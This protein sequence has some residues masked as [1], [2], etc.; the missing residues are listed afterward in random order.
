[1]DFGDSLMSEVQISQ[2]SNASAFS[3]KMYSKTLIYSVTPKPDKESFLNIENLW[4][5]Y[6]NL[7]VS[8][9]TVLLPTIHGKISCL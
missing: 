4:V 8:P 5:Y 1:M 7:K 6:S 9:G 3:Q 2:Q